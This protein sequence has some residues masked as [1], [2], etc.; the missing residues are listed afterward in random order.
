MS[1][2]MTR[3]QYTS[4]LVLSQFQDWKT[5]RLQAAKMISAPSASSSSGTGNAAVITRPTCRPPSRA[6]AAIATTASS[7]T[8]MPRLANQNPHHCGVPSIATAW[9]AP[10]N[11][12]PIDNGSRPLGFAAVP[13]LASHPGSSHGYTLVP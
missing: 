8:A 2:A 3:Y 4:S 10:V 6:T 12:L 7:G 5:T 1:R 13:A 11:T 9:M